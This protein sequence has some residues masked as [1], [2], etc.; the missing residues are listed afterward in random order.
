[1]K[2]KGPA[3][4]WNV[5]GRRVDFTRRPPLAWGI[6][7]ELPFDSL[8]KERLKRRYGFEI[9]GRI[10]NFKFL[11]LNPQESLPPEL[12]NIG[13]END[14]RRTTLENLVRSGRDSQW[15]DI[16]RRQEIEELFFWVFGRNKKQIENFSALISKGLGDT[17]LFVEGHSWNSPFKIG[18][19]SDLDIR[20]EKIAKFQKW[21]NDVAVRKILEK[22]NLPDI[23]SAI[24]FVACYD[25]SKKIRPL[26]VPF[27]Y[28]VGEVGNGRN[29]PV[30]VVSPR[31][32]AP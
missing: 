3:T 22:Y 17:L 18:E 32:F 20:D 2:E 19:K 13:Q 9:P 28:A 10:K 26:D 31:K 5:V 16:K 21:R 29:L 15:A 12:R 23:Y 14:W 8:E 24:I 30:V 4:V 27:V 11:D 1:M 7:I 6:E 25:G